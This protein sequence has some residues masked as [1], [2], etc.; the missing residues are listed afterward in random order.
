MEEI[1][2]YNI[3][4]RKPE[5]ER[6]LGR[7]RRRREDDIRMDVRDIGWTFVDWINLARDRDQWRTHTVMNIRVP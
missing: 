3:L 1:N 2:S 6:L 5:G 4:F 7:T